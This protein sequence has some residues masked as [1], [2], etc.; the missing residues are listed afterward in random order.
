MR[1]LWL[2]AFI[3][4]CVTQSSKCVCTTAECPIDGA[5][6]VIMGGG[7]ANMTYIYETHNDYEVVISA[8]GTITPN[9][10]DN[11][12]G[13]TSCTQKYSRMLEDDGNQN[14]DAGHILAHRLGG[15]GNTPINLFP[16]NLSINR[17]AYAHFEEQ[18]Y[19]CMKNGSEVGELSWDFEY[20]STQRTMP[21]SVKYVAKFDK[22]DCT[23]MSTLFPN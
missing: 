19:N 22:G 14:C 1:F 13:T 15:Y 10:L 18:I 16:Q 20:E 5:N 12:T 21:K 6:H 3:Q 11:G 2:L 8:F 9:A 23:T 17:G 7:N 4:L